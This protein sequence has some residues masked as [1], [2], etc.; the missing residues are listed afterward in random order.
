MRLHVARVGPELAARY[1]ERAGRTARINI[2]LGCSQGS[3]R[4]D[5][6]PKPWL[7]EWRLPRERMAQKRDGV[8]VTASNAGLESIYALQRGGNPETMQSQLV[9]SPVEVVR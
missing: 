1:A 8:D 5:A 9:R 2:V 3:R 7:Q 4:M 6:K